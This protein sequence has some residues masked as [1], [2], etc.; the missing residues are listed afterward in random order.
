MP[1]PR[2]IAIYA[3]S[4]IVAFGISFGIGYVYQYDPQRDLIE[5]VID[6]SAELPRDSNL[7]SGTVREVSETT[8]TV[9]TE[10]GMLELPL[11]SITLEALLPLEEPATVA[12]GTAVN[13]GG[14]RTSTERVISGVVF[15]DG[16]VQP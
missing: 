5:L 15:F 8:V 16:E 10:S 9:E 2:S 14:E 4:L 11:A 6:R 7:I 13:L 12:T 1:T 3:I